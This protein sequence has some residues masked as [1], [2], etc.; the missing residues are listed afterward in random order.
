MSSA[1]VTSRTFEKV[2]PPSVECQRPAGPASQTSPARPGVALIL[3]AADRP[4]AG[5]AA[6]VA[7]PSVL[8]KNVLFANP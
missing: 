2:M 8:T 3:P 4:V 1:I 7:P 5:L 6:N